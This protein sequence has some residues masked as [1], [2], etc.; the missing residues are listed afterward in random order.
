VEFLEKVVDL[1]EELEKFEGE[2]ERD[3]VV[4]VLNF[5]K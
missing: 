5:N 2:L 3:E 1:K 4:E